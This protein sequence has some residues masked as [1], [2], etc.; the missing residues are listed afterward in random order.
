MAIFLDVLSY[1]A[2]ALCVCLFR[3]REEASEVI[4]APMLVQVR[5][6]VGVVFGNPLLRAFAGCMA[7]SNFFSSAFFTL[8]VLFGTRELGLGAA[9]LGL[10]YG[11]G[12][13]GA[14]VG[15]LLAR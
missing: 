9:A 14:V 2:S 4:R 1:L 8:Y 7:T 3:L 11:V 6:G 13:G 12:A 15:A 10:V 5:E